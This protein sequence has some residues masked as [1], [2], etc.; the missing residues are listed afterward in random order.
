MEK[1]AQ[2]L[3]PGDLVRPFLDERTFK[4]TSKKVTILSGPHE[5]DGAFQGI[6]IMFKVLDK[7]KEDE[8][9]LQHEDIVEVL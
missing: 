6:Y 2:E 7:G 1:L 3:K 4:R 9:L 8:I 5:C